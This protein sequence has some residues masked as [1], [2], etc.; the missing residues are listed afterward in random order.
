MVYVVDAI[1]VL[2]EDWRW[3]AFRF[4]YGECGFFSLVVHQFRIEYM[5]VVTLVQS[6]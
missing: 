1:L 5:S 3:E 6:E 2:V 4:C